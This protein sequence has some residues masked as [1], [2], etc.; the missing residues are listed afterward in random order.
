MHSNLQQHYPVALHWKSFFLTLYVQYM[1]N[2]A[3]KK[4][5]SFD[6]ICAADLEYI[7]PFN[8]LPKIHGT[9][10]STLL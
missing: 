9:Y 7:L 1:N 6:L 5:L 10:D 2:P 3:I 4:W 8:I